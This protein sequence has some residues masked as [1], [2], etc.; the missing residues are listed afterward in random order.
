MFRSLSEPFA[1]DSI[2]KL[3]QRG[4]IDREEVRSLLRSTV[5]KCK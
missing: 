5:C 4:E 1:F 2:A 3:F